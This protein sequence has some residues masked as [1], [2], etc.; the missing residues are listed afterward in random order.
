MVVLGLKGRVSLSEDVKDVMI[1]S[2]N[3]PYDAELVF[4]N[5]GNQMIFFLNLK[6]PWMSQLAVSDLFEY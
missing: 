6:S 1:G 2:H 3:N 4:I 5:L